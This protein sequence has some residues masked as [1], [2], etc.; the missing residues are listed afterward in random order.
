MNLLWVAARALLVLI[1]KTLPCGGGRIGRLTGARA[2]RVDIVTPT[3]AI[4]SWK[5][6]RPARRHLRSFFG[7]GPLWSP[8]IVCLMGPG[9]SVGYQWIRSMRIPKMK[10]VTPL[11]SKRARMV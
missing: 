9:L 5:D 10:I 3:D 8:G 6:R 2:R 1:E 7:A 4:F 11:H